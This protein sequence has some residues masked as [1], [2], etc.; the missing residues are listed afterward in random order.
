VIESLALFV[1][2]P[3][4]QCSQP[5]GVHS[6]DDNIT[7][8]STT[9]VDIYDARTLARILT[10]GSRCRLKKPRP[11]IGLAVFS[12][13]REPAVSWTRET[14]PAVVAVVFPRRARWP[15]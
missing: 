6:V 8:K 13:T 7:V 1:A 9:L 12:P 10:P 4:N 15:V 5:L 14:D 11:R 2:E 3:K